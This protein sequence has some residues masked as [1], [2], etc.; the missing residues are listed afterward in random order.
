M[1]IQKNPSSNINNK[2]QG[3]SGSSQISQYLHPNKHKDS[4]TKQE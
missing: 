4:N 2:E 3:V 1:W